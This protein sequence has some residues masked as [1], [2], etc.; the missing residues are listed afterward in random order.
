MDR[1]TDLHWMRKALALAENGRWNTA[2][3]PRVGCII[4]HEGVSIAEG[5][6]AQLGGAHAEVHAL[7]KLEP[8]DE[9]LS[10]STAYVTLEPCNHHGRTPPCT[11]LLMDRGVRRIVVG[12]KDPDPRVAGSG[13]HRLRAGGAQVTVLDDQLRG[14]WLNRRFLSAHERG[15]PWVVLK[16]AISPDG[17]ADPP[18]NRQEQGS[19]PITSDTLK[20]LTHQWRAE[21]QAILV[22]AGTVVVDNPRLDV[23][24]ASGPQPFPVVLDPH[25]RTSPQ[26]LVYQHPGVV[27]LG[28]PRN[29]PKHAVQLEAP[30]GAALET[31]LAHLHQLDCRSVL[32]EG[33]PKTCGGFIES[34]LW[35]EAR[36]CIGSTPTG[37]GIPAPPL[38]PEAKMRGVHPFGN[39]QVRYFVNP[40]S[41]VWAGHAPAPT[42]ALPL[43]A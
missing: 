29:L 23:R 14:R 8:S 5:W 33:G 17:Y 9:R 19:L 21:E 16:C 6:H 13:I 30:V 10:S 18:R 3:N 1:T 20:K 40:N 32:V 24:E 12:M 27:V 4:V 28:G 37:G 25:G 38:P 35:D 2:P 36:W 34:G 41:A 43:P 31:V 11:A 15:R 42:L 22:G 7:G 39:D 26:S